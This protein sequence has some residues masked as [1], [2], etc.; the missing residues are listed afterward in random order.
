MANL[1][2]TRRVG[3]HRSAAEAL[4]QHHAGR[5]EPVLFELAEHWAEAAVCGDRPRAVSRVEQAGHEAMRQHAYEDGRRWFSTALAIGTG[6]DDVARCRL[7]IALAAARSLSSDL[8][9][10]LNY[11]TR[12]RVPMQ[13]S[14]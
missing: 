13:R 9:S 14:A 8:P 1:A 12:S 11:G 10:A 6:P 7:M 3:L 5:P 4:E 2:A